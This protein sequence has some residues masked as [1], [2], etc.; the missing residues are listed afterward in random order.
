[1]DQSKL[2][3]RER[4]RNR[5]TE[6][7]APPA[8][9]RDER[10]PRLNQSWVV[11]LYL[12]L[13]NLA[14]FGAWGYFAY[15]LCLTL[16]DGYNPA[17]TATTLPLLCWVQTAAILEIFHAMLGLVPSAVF[18]TTV[19]IFSRLFV[20]WVPGHLLGLAQNPGYLVLAVAWTLSDLTRYLYY[21]LHLFNICPRFITWARYSLFIVLY[22]LG[23]AGEMSMIWA[24]RE[25]FAK[26]GNM[27]DYLLLGLLGVYPCGFLFMYRHMF[28]QRSKYLRK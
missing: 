28:K 19:Q 12:A 5:S 22:P 16:K 1:M 23:T 4:A 21:F 10:R 15:R 27:Y 8:S 6:D 7:R 20:V 17:K 11:K 9:Y 3:Q 14:S 26:A 13:Y 18:S 25:V 2:T 24:A